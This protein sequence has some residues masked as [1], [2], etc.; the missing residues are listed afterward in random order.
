MHCM[1][2]RH[3]F[4]HTFWYI[5]LKCVIRSTA[6]TTRPTVWMTTSARCWRCMT[7]RPASR[8][9]EVTRRNEKLWEAMRSSAAG[10]YETAFDQKLPDECGCS[11]QGCEFDYLS[12]TYRLQVTSWHFIISWQDK[13]KIFRRPWTRRPWTLR[14]T[15]WWWS[16]TTRGGSPSSAQYAEEDRGGIIS[17]ILPCPY[18]ISQ[19]KYPQ[20]SPFLA[21][22]S[23]AAAYCS[24]LTHFCYK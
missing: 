20:G 23:P 17:F 3:N 2:K 5:N 18:S 10:Y 15:T 11:L 6:R 14:P 1:I 24:L 7:R 22:T 4:S 16:W 12:N 21:Q 19:H 8:P 13:Y 9:W